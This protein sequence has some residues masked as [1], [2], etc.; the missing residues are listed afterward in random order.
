MME[1]K[2]KRTTFTNTPIGCLTIYLNGLIFLR[3]DF[4]SLLEFQKQK[5]LLQTPLILEKLCWVMIWICLDLIN[6]LIFRLLEVEQTTS[7]C[8]L[9][10]LVFFPKPFFFFGVYEM[11]VCLV[12]QKWTKRKNLD[13]I[14][15]A[16]SKLNWNPFHMYIISQHWRKLSLYRKTFLKIII[17]LTIVTNLESFK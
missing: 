16:S 2:W 4:E 6:S 13:E 8:C 15:R 14:E 12:L 3:V 10:V 5:L 1:P 7:I 9:E 17:S 11:V